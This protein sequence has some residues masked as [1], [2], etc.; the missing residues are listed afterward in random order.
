[1]LLMPMLYLPPISYMALLQLAG[2]VRIETAENYSKST[3]RNRCE[4]SGSNGLI[5]LS[6]PLRGGRDHHQ[7]YKNVQIAYDI[8]WQH[9]HRISILSCYG[10]A[11]FFEH[12]M[13]YLEPF[14]NKPYAYLFEYNKELLM[15]IIM[16][17]KLDVRLSYTSVYDRSPTGTTDL[18]SVFKP[19]KIPSDISIGPVTRIFKEVSYMRVF[20]STSLLNVSCLDLLFNEGPQSKAILQQI[21]VLS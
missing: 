20:G 2:E 3:Y 12:Y 13:P 1:M 7:L 21:L 6:I 11:P 8:D 5:D 17:M 10:S 19:G 14:Y 18:R 16:L 9:R 4:I 15:L